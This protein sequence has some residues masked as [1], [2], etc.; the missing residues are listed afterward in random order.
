MTQGWPENAYGCAAIQKKI[1]DEVGVSSGI[2]TIVSGS[3]QI[4]NHYYQQVEDM[5][6]KHRKQKVD[7]NDPRGNYVIEVKD[8][9]IGVCHVDGQSNQELERFEGE[10]AYELGLKISHAG[11]I[12][13]TD[14]AIYLGRELQKAEHALM[15]GKKYEQDVEVN[16]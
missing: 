6:A 8:G 3:A 12:H 16:V 1:A 5:L 7:Y 10:N 11:Q 9:K 15:S 4:Y 13:K 14:H 2:L